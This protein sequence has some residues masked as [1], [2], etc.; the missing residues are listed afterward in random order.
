LCV[1]VYIY[2]LSRA[3]AS[4]PARARAYTPATQ[5]PGR[6]APSPPIGSR[7]GPPAPR[8]PSIYT[9]GGGCSAPKQARRGRERGARIGQYTRGIPRGASL[10]QHTRM[11]VLVRECLGACK[12]GEESESTRADRTVQKSRALLHGP[13]PSEGEWKRERE[14][15]EEEL[16]RFSLDQFAHD[17]LREAPAHTGALSDTRI[18]ALDRGTR[19][20]EP[21][22][23]PTQSPLL[24]REVSIP[25][26][27]TTNPF[28]PW[29]P[30]D[31]LNRRH[32]RGPDASGMGIEAKNQRKEGP[33][34]IWSVSGQYYP[35]LFLPI[36][37]RKKD[38]FLPPC[39]TEDCNAPTKRRLRPLNVKVHSAPL[40]PSSLA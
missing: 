14:M 33:L 29:L 2:Y 28:S 10:G 32:R 35:V 26:P 8:P 36:F 16:S 30:P 25:V 39:F 11:D 21:G 9:G 5:R 31:Y 23:A 3:R 4:R 20:S 6:P 7:I 40:H 34:I 18:G 37:S 1:C 17:W 22:E 19:L 13:R 38:A 27:A 15:D 24:P 12:R